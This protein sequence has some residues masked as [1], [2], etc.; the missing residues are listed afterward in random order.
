MR[1]EVTIQR[2]DEDGLEV[3]VDAGMAVEIAAKTFAQCAVRAMLEASATAGGYGPKMVRAALED[4]AS[5]VTAAIDDELH[6]AKSAPEVTALLRAE[7]PPV[8][9]NEAIRDSATKRL[10][11]VKRYTVPAA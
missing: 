7:L 4:A 8:Q 2:F 1:D 10:V 11:A 6:R 5:K 3:P 9:V